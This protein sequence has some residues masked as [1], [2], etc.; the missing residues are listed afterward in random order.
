MWFPPDPVVQSLE[1]LASCDEG[2]DST[3][4]GSHR[5]QWGV[6]QDRLVVELRLAQIYSGV[7]LLFFHVVVFFL[8]AFLR[9]TTNRFC[10][11][12]EAGGSCI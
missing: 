8:S 12:S 5:R 2:L 1:E 4:K 9:T 6:F 3:A 11:S 7:L 10:R